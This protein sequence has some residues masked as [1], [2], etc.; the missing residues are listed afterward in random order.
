MNAARRLAEGER[1]IFARPDIGFTVAIAD[2][3]RRAGMERKG[4]AEERAI[5]CGNG[6]R[7]ALVGLNLPITLLDPVA[8]N[9]T[10]DVDT[11]IKTMR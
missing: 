2:A 4:G 3:N 8:E 9:G 7:S 11:T 5:D 6:T 1:R 10:V